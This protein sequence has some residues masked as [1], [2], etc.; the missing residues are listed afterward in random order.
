VRKY[1]IVA[2]DN[3]VNACARKSQLLVVAASLV[4]YFQQSN[5]L[6]AEKKL[7]TAYLHPDIQ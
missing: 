3:R 1:V 6:Q 7:R 2:N 5:I 4:I